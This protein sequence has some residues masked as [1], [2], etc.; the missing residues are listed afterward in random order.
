MSAMLSQHYIII[1]QCVVLAGLVPVTGHI[2]IADN[3]LAH[4]CEE[5]LSF[6]LDI[7]LKASCHLKLALLKQL[8]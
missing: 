7:A 4:G 3:D 2:K 8:K 5:T 1:V 6:C